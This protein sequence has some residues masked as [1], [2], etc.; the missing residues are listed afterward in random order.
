[1]GLLNGFIAILFILLFLSYI[2]MAFIQPIAAICRL[3]LERRKDSS[4]AI[5]LKKYLLSVVIYFV[6]LIPLV[7]FE[8]QPELLP[9]FQ[10]YILVV[11]LCMA[12]WY[13]NHIRTWR[14]KKKNIRAFDEMQLLNAPHEDRLLLESYPS[15]K[16]HINNFN[17]RSSAKITKQRKAKIRMMPSLLMK[18]KN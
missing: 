15:K 9:L 3:Y 17:S 4:Y 16:I 11:P 14:K 5:G 2:L 12:I 7:S 13:I 18:V 10:F 6:I 1:M 8:P